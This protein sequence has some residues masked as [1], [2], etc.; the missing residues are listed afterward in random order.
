MEI[1][2][3]SRECNVKI[4]YYGPGL[5]GKTTNLE[6]IHARTPEDNRGN[7]TALATDQDRTLFFDYMPLEI[8]KISGLKVRL[9]LFT[10]PGQ[11]Y[12]NTTRKLVLRCVDG[13]VFVADSQE[14]A[15]IANKES[16][17][18]LRENLQEYGYDI[19]EIPLVIQYNKRDLPQVMS[20]ETLEA[21]L[22]NKLHAQS[23]PAVAIKGDGVFQCLKAI[24]N[25]TMS[26]VE[27][28]IRNRQRVRRDSAPRRDILPPPP[29]L[30]RNRP[31]RPPIPPGDVLNQ[32]KR[33][34]ES[35]KERVEPPSPPKAP[36]E[37]RTPVN[38]PAAVA[39]GEQIVK[40]RI[41]F[42]SGAVSG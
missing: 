37:Q 11:V 21:I 8:G 23:F 9:R 30:S 18:N 29:M 20:L 13:V 41:R 35:P 5:S 1:N 32:F 28:N 12:Y 16:L 36:T 25:L 22:N 19:S 10:V 15:K 2:F 4:V 39:S 17:D 7:L 3:S 34:S 33:A 14:S 42:F 26:R 24:A 6:I 40:G 31:Q 38:P 27:Q